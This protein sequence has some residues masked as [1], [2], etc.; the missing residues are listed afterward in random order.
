MRSWRGIALLVRSC[1]H[2]LGW[3][4]QRFAKLALL[5]ARDRE[6]DAEAVARPQCHHAMFWIGGLLY[7]PGIERIGVTQALVAEAGLQRLAD[8]PGQRHDQRAD[9]VDRQADRRRLA[10]GVNKPQR[11]GTTIGRHLAGGELLGLYLHA[12]GSRTFLRYIHE[13]ISIPLSPSSRH[14]PWRGPRIRDIPLNITRPRT[15]R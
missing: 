12:G 4:R 13:N 1:R 7:H 10:P 3:S 5:L 9:L 8:Q 2:P 15:A 11:N 14:W 6:A